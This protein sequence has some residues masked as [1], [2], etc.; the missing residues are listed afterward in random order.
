LANIFISS[1]GLDLKDYRTA[2][3]EICNRLSIVPIAM[4]F[5]EAM[6]KEASSGSLKKLQMCDAI[7][8]SKNPN[9][10]FIKP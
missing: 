4:E 9:I 6:E 5:F 1:T 7:F 8:V 3:I 10:S 2:A